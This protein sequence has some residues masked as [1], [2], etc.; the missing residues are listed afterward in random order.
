MLS[1]AINLNNKGHVVGVSDVTLATGET[2]HAF[3][4]TKSNGMLDLQT[5][6][7]DKISSA[8][9]IND[10]DQ[11][12][13]LS[14]SADGMLR[15]FVWQNGTMRDLNDLVRPTF[16]HLLLGGGI[17]ASGEIAGIAMDTRN[18]EVHGFTATPQ[19]NDD[20]RDNA[21]RLFSR[22]DVRRVL[23]RLGPLSRHGIRF[24]PER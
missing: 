20:S 3:L 12:T 15:A 17:N 22:E 11:I 2:A 21:E 10:S 7:G 4:W 24:V 18:G 23:A 14:I 16:L 6:P 13:G 5:L 9:G 1:F 19:G 8:V